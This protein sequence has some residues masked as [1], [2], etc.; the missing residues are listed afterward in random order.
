MDSEISG[1]GSNTA[2]ILGSMTGSNVLNKL[3]ECVVNNTNIESKRKFT[4]N[5][6]NNNIGG[7]IGFAN[8]VEL[9]NCIVEKGNDKGL[10]KGVGA[11]ISGGVAA[12]IYIE[13]NNCSIKG[14]NVENGTDVL[15]SSGTYR[16]ISGF[17]GAGSGKLQNINV[18]NVNISGVSEVAGGIFAYMNNAKLLSKKSKHKTT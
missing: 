4:G 9:N 8:K 1:W 6:S 5:Y 3:N 13:A 16:T 7:L 18:E 14:I 10:V 2:G 11:Q 15:T 17:L 12:G